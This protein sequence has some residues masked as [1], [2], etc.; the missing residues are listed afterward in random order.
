MLED[1]DMQSDSLDP[2]CPPELPAGFR[3]VK[4]Q[5]TIRTWLLAIAIVTLVLSTISALSAVSGALTACFPEAILQ[6]GSKTGNAALDNAQATLHQGLI[7]LQ[8][9]YFAMVFCGSLV[10]LAASGVA[11]V[12]GVFALRTPPRYRILFSSGCV[13]YMASE[14]LQVGAFFVL[15]SQSFELLQTFVE[16]IASANNPGGPPLPIAAVAK[17]GMYVSLV[18][19]LIYLLA[20]L[21]F[22][23]YAVFFLRREDVQRLYAGE[24]PADVIQAEV[25]K[26]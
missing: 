19:T 17:V 9:K 15:Q 10:A 24:L 11:F 20:K 16:E 13:A 25:A 23:T 14:V 8:R 12:G 21:G 3:Q 22:F 26:S 6:S 5:A 7:D 1:L 18:L 4:Q 2:Y